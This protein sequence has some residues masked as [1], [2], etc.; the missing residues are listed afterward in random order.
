MTSYLRR[1]PGYDK[2]LGLKRDRLQATALLFTHKSAGQERSGYFGGIL[3]A[4]GL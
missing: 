3:V 4:F 1:G 2:S